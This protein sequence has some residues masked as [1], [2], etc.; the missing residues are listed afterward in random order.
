MWTVNTLLGNTR[1]A[2]VVAAVTLLVF[3]ANAQ[4][5]LDL[6]F[7]K[8]KAVGF[9]LG[10]PASVRDGPKQIVLALDQSR[11][12]APFTQSAVK[13][14]SAPALRGPNPSIPHFVVR[15]A[16]PIPPDN[17]TNLVGA[18]VGLDEEVWAHNHSPGLEVLPN[19]DLL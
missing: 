13:Q 11:S 16:L 5:R 6:D 9:Q 10:E 4:T 15:F 17:D 12:P 8:V 19:G 1:I 3:R 14:D 7:S 2:A 18:A